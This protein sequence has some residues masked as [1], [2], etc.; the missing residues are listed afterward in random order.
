MTILPRGYV[1]DTPRDLAAMAALLQEAWNPA[2]RPYPA[3]TSAI[4]IGGCAT[5]RTNRLSGYGRTNTAT[6]RALPRVC[7]TEAVPGEIEKRAKGH[8]DGWQSTK[9]TVEEHQR[10]MQM[11][12]YHHEPDIVVVAPD[13]C[14][15]TFQWLHLYRTSRAMT[16]IRKDGLMRLPLVR[17]HVFISLCRCRGRYRRQWS[18]RCSASHMPPF[19]IVLL[20]ASARIFER[21]EG[22][23]AAFA[24]DSTVRLRVHPISR[25]QNNPV[26]GYS[27][28]EDDFQVIRVPGPIFSSVVSE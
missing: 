13:S 26:I 15:R 3:C 8:G 17:F 7:S 14:I 6:S 12:G 11:P 25:R 27:G 2:P 21:R 20:C 28:W 23:S 5:N 16:S 10:L 18:W 24:R 1:A 4:S 22:F 9:M 19:A